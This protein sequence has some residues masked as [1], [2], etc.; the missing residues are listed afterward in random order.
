LTA[1]PSPSEKLEV[2]ILVRRRPGASQRIEEILRGD[3]PPVSRDNGAELL[4]ADPQDVQQVADFAASHGLTVTES[5]AGKRALKVSGTLAQ[6]E[7]ACGIRF[8][9]CESD[10]KTY[11]CYEGAIA[12]PE[13]IRP[14][15]TG[16][17]G[18]DQR[19]VAR[20]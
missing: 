20:R 10:G 7:A 9:T 15:V 17:L 13:S 19:P 2:T 6:M 5:S 11:L 14:L 8:H 3:A 18:L 16:V 4:G 12:I 1:D